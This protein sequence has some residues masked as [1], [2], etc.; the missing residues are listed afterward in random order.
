[1]P[2]LMVSPTINIYYSVNDTV[3]QIPEG[4]ESAIGFCRLACMHQ[5]LQERENWMSCSYARQKLW[6]SF[7]RSSVC[8]YLVKG[9]FEWQRNEDWKLKINAASSQPAN[10]DIFSMQKNLNR[11][12]DPFKILFQDIC[13]FFNATKF[14]IW[15]LVAI[16]VIYDA[17]GLFITT[18]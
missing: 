6:H 9:L 8:I 5:I 15:G 17:N 14:C 4:L 12:A 18:Q 10:F 2:L 13:G 7:I 16:L 3:W 11:A 1:M